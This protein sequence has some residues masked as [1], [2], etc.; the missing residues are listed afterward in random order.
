MRRTE[1]Q[2]QDPFSCIVSLLF[3]VSH[4]PVNDVNIGQ[5][6]Q[7]QLLLSEWLAPPRVYPLVHYILLAYR[8]LCERSLKA[9]H[10]TPFEKTKIIPQSLEK[11]ILIDATYVNSSTLSYSCTFNSWQFTMK[12]YTELHAQTLFVHLC[13]RGWWHSR[14]IFFFYCWGIDCSDGVFA[15]YLAQR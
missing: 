9:S 5:N 3:D 10:T 6:R 4:S 2:R 12:P 7:L 15:H 8:W 1:E 14:D 13:Y 11:V